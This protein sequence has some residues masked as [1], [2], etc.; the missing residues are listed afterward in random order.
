ML[1]ALI[2][3]LHHDVG[4]QMRDAH[5]GVGGIHV[6][7]ALA[8]GAIGVDAQLVRLDIDLDGIVN[9]RRDKDAGKRGVTALGLVE[10]RN[11]HQPVHSGFP[12]KLAE[13]VLAGHGK[14]SGLD[15]RLFAILVV[16]DLGLEAVPLGPTKVHAHQHL[17]PVLRF[18]A[19]GARVDSH[20][21]IERIGLRRKHGAG[22][23]LLHELA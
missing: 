7:A 12:G 8:A 5:R 22:L 13:G 10:G 4:R 1:G 11:A 6:L 15:T 2:L 18:G 20:D 3:A 9:L 23:E 21:C 17:G 14:S 19:A 16:I